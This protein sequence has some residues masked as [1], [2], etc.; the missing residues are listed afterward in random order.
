MRTMSFVLSTALL[1][2]ASAASAQSQSYPSG[3]PGDT[4]QVQ[5]IA[6][7]PPFKFRSDQAAWISGAYKMSNGWRLQVDPTYDGITAQIDKR[8]PIELVAVSP[9]RYVSSDGN[10]SMEFN[11]GQHGDEMLMSY[12]PDVRTAQVVVVSAVTLAQR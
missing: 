5:V 11:R 9:D 8:R 6:Q 1:L 4:T 3:Q 10:V 7:A 12:V 2:L